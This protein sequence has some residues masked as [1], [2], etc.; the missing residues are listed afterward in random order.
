MGAADVTIKNWQAPGE[1]RRF[2][3]D[4]TDI[5]ESGDTITGTPTFTQ[6]HPRGSALTVAFVQLLATSTKVEAR[7][8]GGTNDTEYA[9]TC[10][11]DTTDGDTLRVVGQL[12]ITQDEV[13]PEDVHIIPGES[14]LYTF[15][16][17]GR[18]YTSDTLASGEAVTQ[19]AGQALTITAVS[20]AS[21]KVTARVTDAVHGQAY[22]LLAAAVTTGGDTLNIIGELRGSD[23]P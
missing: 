16:F 20:R 15:D 23:L 5:L 14:R 6:T 9:I 3:F 2:T 22:K 13:A 12:R 11:A 19:L 1:S 18:L 4:F 10:D 7:I 21:N 17:A 8:S